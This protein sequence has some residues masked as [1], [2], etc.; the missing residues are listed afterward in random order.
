MICEFLIFNEP[1]LFTKKFGCGQGEDEISSKT[2]IYTLHAIF[3]LFP[4]ECLR[5]TPLKIKFRSFLPLPKFEL[6]A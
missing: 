3:Q 5:Q 4:K 6:C 2:Y 1:G